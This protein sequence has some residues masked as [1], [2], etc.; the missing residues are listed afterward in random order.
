MAVWEDSTPNVE[1]RGRSRR[2]L[3]PQVM[4]LTILRAFN[5]N[6]QPRATGKGVGGWVVL[7]R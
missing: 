4:E 7:S 3:P 1:L 2:G 6:K 5:T